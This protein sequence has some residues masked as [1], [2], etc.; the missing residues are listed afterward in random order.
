MLLLVAILLP[1]IIIYPTIFP[2]FF[3]IAMEVDRGSPRRA[4]GLGE[5]RPLCA[6][7][8][9]RAPGGSSKRRDLGDGAIPGA[10]FAA[11]KMLR[12]SK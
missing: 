7:L 9:L 3:P 8:G 10:T 5:E 6:A 2:P 4:G 11:R 1:Y 12:C